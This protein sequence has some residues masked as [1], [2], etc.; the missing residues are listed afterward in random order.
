MANTNLTV[1]NLDFGSIKSSLKTHLTGQNVLKDYDFDGSNL[2]V[3]L[4]V[5]SYNTYM[6]NFYLNMVAGESFLDSAQLR[7]SVVSHAKI[8]NYLPS[9]T[10]SSKATIN[11][12]IYPDD[13]PA[14]IILPKYTE[15]TSMVGSNTYTF[16]TDTSLT[17]F[18][19][20]NGNYSTTNL[21]I[22]EGEVVTE[23]FT[24]NTS[25]T[26][27]RFVLSNK[28]IDTSSL[29]VKITQSQTEHANSAWTK[30]KGI[31]GMTGSSNNY[32]LEPCENEKYEVQFGDGV[33]GRKLQNGNI[34]EAKYRRA[35]ADNADGAGAFAL[36]GDIQGY[37]NVFITVSGNSAGGGSA[38]SIESI[39]FNAPK[40]ISIQDRLVTIQ[41]YKTLLK[42]EFND[43][44][45]I[46][47]YGGDT[48]QPPK[49]GKVIISVDLKNADGISTVRK[50]DI[51]EFVRNRAPLSI[52]PEVVNPE[53]L[54]VDIT[55]QV[56]YNPNVTVKGPEEIK[57]AV[58]SAIDTFM[59][60]S[61]N[62]FE[63]KLRRSR[64][65]RNIDDSD[66]SILNN[67]TN[68]LLTKSIVPVLYREASYDLSFDNAIYREIPNGSSDD[69]VF[70]DGTA[71]L[72]STPFTFNEISGC[73]IRDNGAGVLQIIQDIT[74]TAT[75][76]RDKIGTIDYDTGRVQVT[77]LTVSQ[78]DGAGIT[79]RCNPVSQTVSSS[80]NIILSY[81]KTPKITVIQER[82]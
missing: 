42:Q 56:V 2:S 43:I 69:I 8:L 72:E 23:L 82:I 51:E 50:Q 54:F 14:S 16:T 32:F 59:A 78:Y 57:S 60:D 15:F 48:I 28:D 62:D 34:V 68:V 66:P 79:F 5:L 20:A 76:V 55:T 49:F 65:V 70:V 31:A 11:M 74:G 1:A 12:N 77:K 37:S 61:I 71:P 30:T 22:Y 41:D 36:S 13:A 53:F 19:D 10:T 21:D 24:V 29:I 33:L 45:A 3:M 18:A 25:N 44:E 67:N 7:D 46:N 73:S 26:A 35:A 17:I 47:V 39:K 27:Q 6:N 81:N 80:K 63:S 4:D 52:R 75:V 38:E 64:L 9:S 40:S 58:T